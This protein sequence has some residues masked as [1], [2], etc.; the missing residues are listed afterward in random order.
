M[1][2]E[3]ERQAQEEAAAAAERERQR[4]QQQEE[5]ERRRK[6]Q[7]EEE[8]RELEARKRA[9]LEREEQQ[10]LA[11][12][13]AI[14][15]AQEEEERREAE[16]RREEELA[17]AKLVGQ[18]QQPSSSSVPP[19]PPPPPPAAPSEPVKTEDVPASPPLPP[20]SAA[21][22]S[23][24]AKTEDVPAPPPPTTTTATVDNTRTSRMS[25]NN[26]FAKLQQQEKK[27]EE[28]EEQTVSP[29]SNTKRMSYNPFAAFSAFSATKAGNDESDSDDDD[30][31][32]DVVHH[33]DTDDED[34]FPAAGSAKNLAGMLFDAMSQ[35][36]QQQKSTSKFELM[37][38][39]RNA[40]SPCLLGPSLS[41]AAAPAAPPAPAPPTTTTDLPAAPSAG[42]RSALLSQIQQGTK[43]RKTVTN[44]RSGAALAGRVLNSASSTDVI[45]PQPTA[46]SEADHVS[47]STTAESAPE[48]EYIAQWAYNGQGEDDLSF[49]QDAK[50]L[51][52]NDDPDQDWWYGRLASDS[53]KKGFFPKSYVKDA[54]GM[55]KEK[56]PSVLTWLA[57]IH[58]NDNTA[59]LQLQAKALYD[60]EGPAEE[61]CLSFH[62]GASLVIL[63][64]DEEDWWKAE[65]PETGRT[66]LVPANYVQLED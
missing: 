6:Q 60:F 35:R 38:E 42:G 45:P 58:C 1:R 47:S 30:D 57:H 9:V 37:R 65:I 66:G 50:I 22:P 55:V 12:L 2:Q 4:I 5:E 15:R 17:K 39:K 64:K 11:R 25:S 49:D 54:R 26:P 8:E 59:T 62:A 36:Q 19:P 51:V 28:E 40:I 3:S 41:S 33:D 56:R 53:N 32:W 43:L 63:E 16:R 10:R 7:E 13:E 18:Q 61:G 23:E 44:D 31:G 34:E 14:Q 20:S 21:A 29:V 48:K 46:P 24:S 27:K 52:Q